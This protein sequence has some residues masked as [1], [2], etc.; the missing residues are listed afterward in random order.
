MTISNSGL[1]S[2]FTYF[3]ASLCG[4]LS[5]LGYKRYILSF[6]AILSYFLIR[7]SPKMIISNSGLLS[8]I[9]LFLGQFMQFFCH[10]W[11]INI[12]FYHFRLFWAIF[13][14]FSIFPGP[15]YPHAY[16]EVLTQKLHKIVNLIKIT[17]FLKKN[18]I[19]R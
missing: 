13:K 2:L 14:I 11:A 7:H 17:P 19:C 12:K 6:W 3:Q 9:F 5:Y 16:C 1:V 15:P 8:L 4:F 18:R 10:F